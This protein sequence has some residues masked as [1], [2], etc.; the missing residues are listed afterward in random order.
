MRSV[1]AASIQ[2][3]FQPAARSFGKTSLV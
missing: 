3:P 2:W 1:L